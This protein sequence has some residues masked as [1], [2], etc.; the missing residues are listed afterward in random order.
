MNAAPPVPRDT[1]LTCRLRLTLETSAGDTVVEVAAE[2]LFPD[3][4]N[5]DSLARLSRRVGSF[6]E[7]RALIE[8]RRG[9]RRWAEEQIPPRCDTFENEFCRRVDAND[10]VI[11]ALEWIGPVTMTDAESE[12]LH[13]MANIILARQHNQ[14]N[15]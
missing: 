3:G 12:W 11:D 5:P 10:D 13:R 14:K 2:D 7:D 9:V 6:I 4:L 8:L 15:R 1:D